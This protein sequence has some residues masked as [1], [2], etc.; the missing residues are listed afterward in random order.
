[1][2]RFVLWPSWP[3]RR[4][5][6]G[7]AV[8]ILHDQHCGLVPPVEHKYHQDVPALMAGTHKIHV[9]RKIPLRNLA[10]VEDKCNAGKQVHD[11][12]SGWEVLHDSGGGSSV[13]HDPVHGGDDTVE[14]DAGEDNQA[15]GIPLRGKVLR[16]DVGKE[17]QQHD[18]QHRHQVHLPP[19]LFTVK[20]I[21]YSW[22]V[23]SQ[24]SNR[25]PS[26]VQR[27]PAPTCLLRA[28]AAKEVVTSR[29][30]HA[31]LEAEEED[32]VDDVIVV[33]CLSGW[34]HHQGVI[35]P[36]GEEEQESKEVA[37]DIHSLIGHNEQAF[38]AEA[39]G[40][41][42]SI[43]VRDVRVSFQ[44]TRHLFVGVQADSTWRQHRPV[45]VPPLHVA[46]RLQQF[47]WHGGQRGL[48]LT[49]RVPPLVPSSPAGTTTN[50]RPG[51]VVV[52][53]PPP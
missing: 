37:P 44:E 35:D 28:V 34:Q 36:E 6:A 23:T 45:A 30:Q 15:R 27:Q 8:A 11:H 25:Y 53:P 41:V 10:N 9:A 29:A 31:H 43:S 51:P 24:Q 33:W 4:L 38:K 18:G 50:A 20:G 48:F 1:M 2:Q 40:Q 7:R 21:K 47:V 14:R 12:H 16:M 19:V 5:V 52:H 49:A 26:V 17:D 46:H 22:Y 3:E 39:R 42:C 13:E 32:C